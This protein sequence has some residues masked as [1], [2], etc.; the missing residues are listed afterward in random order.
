MMPRHFALASLMAAMLAAATSAG[1]VV[2]GS[3]SALGRYTVR[4]FGNGSCSGVA[5]ARTAVAT[6]AHCAEGM[7]VLAGGR[8]FDV[9][10][11]VS[12]AVLDDGRQVSVSGDAAILQLSTP[13]PASVDVAP[14]GEGEGETYIIAG[15]GSGKLLEARLVASTEPRAL[16]DPNRTGSIGASACFGDSG[17]PV[18]HG[19]ML[20]GVITRGY[21]PSPNRACGYLTRWAPIV[22]SNTAPTAVGAAKAESVAKLHEPKQLRL[23]KRTPMRE[24]IAVGLI[25]SRLAPKVE[26]AGER[27]R[28]KLKRSEKNEPAE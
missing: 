16:V 22:A 27:S 2:K 23:A 3:P 28:S 15:Y 5:I 24:S 11:I 17:G 1:A 19:G 9:A 12:S 20:V 8:S 4:L 10:A 21:H 18:M 7:S 13:L 26:A 25:G 14:I 6:A